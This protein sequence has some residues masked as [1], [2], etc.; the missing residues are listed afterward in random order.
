[1]KGVRTERQEGRVR[2]RQGGGRRPAQGRK[3][4]WKTKKSPGSDREAGGSELR[5]G[6]GP[7]GPGADRTMWRFVEQTAGLTKK[8]PR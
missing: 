8:N 7:R 2:K 3:K 1:M 4:A 6:V 5:Q